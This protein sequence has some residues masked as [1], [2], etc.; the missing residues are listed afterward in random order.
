MTCSKVPPICHLKRLC[1]Q[2]TIETEVINKWCTKDAGPVSF[3]EAWIGA[4]V[5]VSADIPTRVMEGLQR[6]MGFSHGWGQAV[7][8]SRQD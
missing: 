4:M 7:T 2:S 8:V 3:G 6:V 5:V 1:P